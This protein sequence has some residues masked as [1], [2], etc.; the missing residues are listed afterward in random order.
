MQIKPLFVTFEGPDA[1]GKS[2]VCRLLLEKLQNHFNDASK[3]ILTR[4]PGGTVVGEKIREILTNFN[5][6]PRTEALLFAA[7]R[8]ENTWKNINFHKAQNK[9]ILCDRYVHS[10][11]VYQ[12]VVKN[13][14]FK[15]IFKINRFAIGKLKPDIVFYFDI[16]EKESYKRKVNDQNRNN[17]DRLENEF[18]QEEKIKKVINAYHT[19][20]TFDNR[21]I[22]KIDAN[23]PIEEITN[24]IFDIILSRAVKNG[25]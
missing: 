7:S 9:I 14:G 11:Y 16:N 17:N 25:K 2:T 10:S 20:L 5:V 19:I 6:D 12:G 22:V 1:C 8:A 15:N 4:E 13:L 21:N 23:K 3:V 18:A 24:K